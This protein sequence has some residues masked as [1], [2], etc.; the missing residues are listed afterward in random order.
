ML[1]YPSRQRSIDEVDT[2][3]V[4]QQAPKHEVRKRPLVRGALET[5]LVLGVGLHAERRRE[6]ELAN[7]GAE[8]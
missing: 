2:E 5:S 1:L 7:A 4:Q 3:K 6:H 8:S